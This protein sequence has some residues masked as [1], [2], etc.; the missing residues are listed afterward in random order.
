MILLATLLSVAVWVFINRL[1]LCRS[2]ERAS[3]KVRAYLITST[4]FVAMTTFLAIV[5]AV[6]AIE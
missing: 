2:G 3:P 6:A 1:I 4:I 5:L